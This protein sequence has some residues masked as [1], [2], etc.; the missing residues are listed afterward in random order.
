MER[1]DMFKEY[2]QSEIIILFFSFHQLIITK[3]FFYV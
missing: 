2:I 3:L 1:N